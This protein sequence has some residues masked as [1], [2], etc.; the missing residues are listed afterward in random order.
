[1]ILLFRLRF[2]AH[3]Q[4]YLRRPVHTGTESVGKDSHD[5][6]AE[7]AA[8][9]G[10]ALSCFVAYRDE[11][12]LLSAGSDGDDGEAGV[13]GGEEQNPPGWRDTNGQA[14]DLER[15][16]AAIQVS[17]S[18]KNTNLDPSTTRQ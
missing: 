4:K 2:V 17:R 6:T 7:R 8:G 11:G 5:D 1:M 3:A 9:G 15:K 13:E 16:R 14:A 10:D 12:K 18:I